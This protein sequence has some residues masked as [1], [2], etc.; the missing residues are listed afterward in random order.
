MVPGEILRVRKTDNY[1]IIH[2]SVFGNNDLSWEARGVLAYLLSK[3]DNWT[4]RVYDLLRSGQC[5]EHKMAR[6]LKELEDAGYLRRARIQH[7]D[8]RFDWHTTVYEEP[9]ADD[10]TAVT[11]PRLPGYGSPMDGSTADGKPLDIIITDLLKTDRTTTDLDAGV[12]DDPETA[13]VARIM[14]CV[15][16]QMGLDRDRLRAE[17]V[18]EMVDEIGLEYVVQAAE[19][20]VRNGGHSLGY[21]EQTARNLSEGKGAPKPPG[22]KAEPAVAGGQRWG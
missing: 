2:N 21:L 1:S 4:V 22:N 20:M 18:L 17:M 14:Q 15:E 16:T 10:H 12:V 5:G 8:G 3:P 7:D 13:V 19:L 6:I 11:I 9:R